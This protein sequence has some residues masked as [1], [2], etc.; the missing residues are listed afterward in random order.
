MSTPQ[1]RVLSTGNPEAIR[2]ALRQMR[3]SGEGLKQI[4]DH[5]TCWLAV[6][7]V[8]EADAEMLAGEL[9]V[10]GGGALLEHRAGTVDM[11]LVGTREQCFILANQLGHRP[12]PMALWGKEIGDALRYAEEPPPALVLGR[13]RFNFAGRAYVDAVVNVTPDSFYDGG[14]H[15]TVSAAV[16]YALRMVEQGA[17]ILE[18]GGE[19]A[20]PGKQVG[21]QQEIDRV[22]GVI[23]ELKRRTEIPISIDTRRFDVARIAVETGADILNDT[24]SLADPRMIG[25]VV[26]HRT[27]L[28]LM[29]FPGRPGELPRRWRYHD[30]V[31]HVCTFLRARA[32]RALAA[33]VPRSRIIVDPGFGFHKT[34]AQDLEVLRRLPELRSLG[35]AIMLGT[36]N[37]GF[38]EYATGLGVGER[39]EAT[40]ATVAYGIA[41]GAHIVRVHNVKEM[42]R[43][44][45][46]MAATLTGK[47]SRL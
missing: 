43:V 26:R 38:L 31:D 32:D 2:P 11:V 17:D 22:A 19:S 4:E 8:T 15:A 1:V 35:Y 3:L 46:M 12:Q 28:V 27:A 16:D 41:Q 39:V 40:A 44:V 33:G 36:S 45:H 47:P 25:L 10:W 9:R 20:G 13:N 23:A 24:Q 42:A 6:N 37:R 21:A 18:I 29:H 34:D 30:V 14:R 7:G 5:A